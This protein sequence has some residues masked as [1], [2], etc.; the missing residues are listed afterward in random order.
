M[1]AVKCSVNGCSKVLQP[2]WKPDPSDR[3][4]WVYPECD[5]CFRPA[6]DEHV[7]E[8]E[9]QRVCGRCLEKLET[10]QKLQLVALDERRGE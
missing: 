5:V 10:E 1:P 2:L 7:T 9:G 6:C 8:R 3:A 4:T